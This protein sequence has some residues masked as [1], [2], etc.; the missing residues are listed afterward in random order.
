MTT[1]NLEN[2]FGA[3]LYGGLRFRLIESLWEY[4]RVSGSLHYQAT[5][6]KPGVKIAEQPDTDSISM[7]RHSIVFSL[8]FTGL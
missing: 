6:L 8:E 2:A 1:G 4:A 3:E 7:N 5:L